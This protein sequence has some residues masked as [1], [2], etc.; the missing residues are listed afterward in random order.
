MRLL[1][2]NYEFPP[3][4]GGAAHAS[5][6][7]AREFVGLNHQVDFLTIATEGSRADE[8]MDGI[9]VHRVRAYRRGIHESGVVGALTFLGFAATRLRQLARTNHYDAYH[10]YFSLPTG[11]LALVPGEHRRQ[12]YVVS[13][14]GSDVPG[15]DPA[16]DWLHRTLLPVTRR[17]WRRAYR[18]VTNSANLRQMALN[19]APGLTVDVILNGT[20]VTATRSARETRTGLRILVVS[21]L[22]ARKGIDTLIMALT[23]PG[24]EDLSLDIAG[25]GPDSG[26][27]RRL[28]HA[29]GVA[30]RIRFHGFVSRAGLAELYAAADIFV[31]A[32]LAESCSMALLEAMGAG[33]PLVASNVG[34]TVELIEHGSNGLLFKPQNVEELAAALHTL[35]RNPALRERFAAA[36]RALAHQ[37]FS[38]RAVA[39]QYEAIFQ[40]AT[41]QY[42]YQQ[43]AEAAAHDELTLRDGRHHT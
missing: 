19:S 7:L 43:P 24:N 2:L 18:V 30:A 13:L 17:I 29:C 22:I 15:Y 38:W 26:T 23:K 1:F 25:E 21:R 34:G 20:S 40:R 36:N 32:S 42:S 31:L 12:P 4:G 6:A 35:A 16:L 8:F 28:A 37:H 10:Y 5:L 33:L 11:L 3:V 27:L 39:R 14:R 41:G 9:H